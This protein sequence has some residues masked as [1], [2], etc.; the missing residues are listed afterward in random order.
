MLSNCAVV[1]AKF[2][3]IKTSHT[4]KTSYCMDVDECIQNINLKKEKR[5]KN[6]AQ[7][8]INDYSAVVKL[9]SS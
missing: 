3:F 4:S 1:I 8:M 6:P 7:R 5:M 2:E 9:L